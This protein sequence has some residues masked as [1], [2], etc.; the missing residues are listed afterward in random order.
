MTPNDPVQPLKHMSLPKAQNNYDGND[1]GKKND[2]FVQNSHFR[3]YSKTIW[4]AS[5]LLLT[6]SHTLTAKDR[7]G[8]ILFDRTMLNEIRIKKDAKINF[9]VNVGATV[10]DLTEGEEYEF[11]VIAVNKSGSS[12]SSETSKT[13]IAKPT[14]CEFLTIFLVVQFYGNFSGQ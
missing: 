3:K 6:L 2:H 5:Q 12:D 1:D 7:I 13:I 10:P 14:N 4:L 8:N 9:N 11:R